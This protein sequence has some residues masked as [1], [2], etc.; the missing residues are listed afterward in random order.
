M[1]ASPNPPDDE[2]RLVPPTGGAT[3]EEI[4]QQLFTPKHL[5]VEEAASPS[6]LWEWD[7]ILFAAESATERYEESIMEGAGLRARTSVSEALWWFG[8]ALEFIQDRIAFKLNGNAD[9]FYEGLARTRAGRLLGAL[10][11]LR[12]RAGHDLAQV[13]A[14]WTEG[15]AT[16]S[17]AKEDATL[18]PIT[19]TFRGSR[20]AH[21]WDT[22]PGHDMVFA[23]LET[24]HAQGV[25]RTTDRYQRDSWYEEL[26][27]G[28]RASEV[29]RKVIAALRSMLDVTR[30]V[31]HQQGVRVSVRLG[32]DT[33][34]Q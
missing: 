14:E 24:L 31:E 27:E 23:H 8:C 17:I 34:R 30:S 5:S 20:A 25:R 33:T 18:E 9:S 28:E 12:N 10:Y 1:P 29:L 15:S 4:T 13:L 7:L 22:T 16:G 3:L 2:D 26:V 32:W 6:A 21:R 19:V 11:Y